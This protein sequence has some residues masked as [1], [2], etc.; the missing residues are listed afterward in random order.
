VYTFDND[1]A[2]KLYR[3]LLL[4][5]LLDHSDTVRC[6]A[7]CSAFVDT[8]TKATNRKARLSD[9]RT[10]SESCPLCE[11]LL[12]AAEHY[13]DDV[14]P[15]AELVREGAALRIGRKGPRILR[16]CTDPSQRP[17]PLLSAGQSHCLL[18]TLGT[19]Y[20]R[21]YRDDIPI[22]FPVLPE[23][24]SPACFALLREWLNWCD[25]THNCNKHNAES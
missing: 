11:I 21:V 4:R 22:G 15:D 17:E 25:A 23:P 19:E 16:L 7:C 6:C 24:E 5:I 12:C 13:R 2:Q 3:A 20:P 8:S 9:I 18:T 1:L 14:G 10:A